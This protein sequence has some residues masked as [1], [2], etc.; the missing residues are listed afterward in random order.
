[1]GEIPFSHEW[2]DAALQLQ[3]W[4]AVLNWRNKGEHKWKI[5]R[6]RFLRKEA[7]LEGVFEMNPLEIENQVRLEKN[8]KRK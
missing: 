2:Q 5:R 6:V 8:V 3:A 4:L 1:M 7:K